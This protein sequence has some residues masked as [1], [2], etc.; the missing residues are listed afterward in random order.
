MKKFILN[1][2]KSG[3]SYSAFEH[4]IVASEYFRGVMPNLL[5]Y[6]FIVFHRKLLEQITSLLKGTVG[7]KLHILMQ[8]ANF[9]TFNLTFGAIS[10]KEK[11]LLCLAS[12]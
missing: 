10:E 11:K 3:A 8:C 6:A 12:I 1:K 2:N 7:G 4:S 9:K 5:F